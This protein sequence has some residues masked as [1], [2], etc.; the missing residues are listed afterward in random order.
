MS[1]STKKSSTVENDSL[2]LVTQII[3]KGRK[4]LKFEEKKLMK[5]GQ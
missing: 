4:V 2:L 1:R 5:K 3:N